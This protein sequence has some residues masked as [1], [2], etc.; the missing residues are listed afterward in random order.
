MN[1]RERLIAMLKRGDELTL[2]DRRRLI[3]YLQIRAGSNI[4]TRETDIPSIAEAERLARDS[5]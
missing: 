5:A 3:V 1:E 4:R 2:D